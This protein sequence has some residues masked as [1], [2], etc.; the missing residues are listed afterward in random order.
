MDGPWQEQKSPD[1]L[2]G[3][4]GM[5]CVKVQRPGET[6]LGR[7]SMW[8]CMTHTRNFL[9]TINLTIQCDNKTSFCARTTLFPKVILLFWTQWITLVKGVC[10][11]I[12]I[13]IN[14]IIPFAQLTRMFFSGHSTVWWVNLTNISGWSPLKYGQSGAMEIRKP[15]KKHNFYRIRNPRVIKSFSCLRAYI[16]PMFSAP[17]SRFKGRVNIYINN[18]IYIYLRTNKLYKSMGP[19]PTTYVSFCNPFA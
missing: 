14:N 15:P 19:S 12:Y 6:V 9:P 13:C 10:V 2:P 3:D 5:T 4:P 18:H 11:Y 17:T 7:H 16:V 8:G 1:A